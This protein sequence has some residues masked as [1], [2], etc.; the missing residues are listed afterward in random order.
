M[1][2]IINGK[3][4][5]TD[6]ANLLGEWDNGDNGD[7]TFVIERL[8][9]KINGEYFLYGSGGA[10]TEYALPRGNHTVSGSRCLTPLSDADARLWS[11]THLSA[12]EHIDLFGPVSE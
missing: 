12:D 2:K 10:L 4:Y 8:Y 6:T 5:D 9:Q 7:F 1:K 11:E 3:L